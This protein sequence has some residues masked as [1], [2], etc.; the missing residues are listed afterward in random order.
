MSQK[1]G[2]LIDGIQ[3]HFTTV[4]GYQNKTNVMMQG[5]EDDIEISYRSDTSKV[6]W[7]VL[8]VA[9]AGMFDT[10]TE[11]DNARPAV[12]YSA[13]SGIDLIESSYLTW[14]TPHFIVKK[15][16]VNNVTINWPQWFGTERVSFAVLK[17]NQRKSTLSPLSYRA[18]FE[19]F[20]KD[21]EVRKSHLE[22]IGTN[23]EMNR[24]TT[25]LKSYTVTVVQPWFYTLSKSFSIKLFKLP[26]DSVTHTYAF[27]DFWEMLEVRFNGELV[28]IEHK[29]MYLED[30]TPEDAK[31][32]N[33]NPTMKFYV[34]RLHT[35]EQNQH[36]DVG[37][38]SIYEFVD[39][40]LKLV[41]SQGT[42]NIS[43]AP[44]D[45]TISVGGICRAIFWLTHECETSKENIISG[46]VGTSYPR[47]P[48]NLPNN[49]F[50][51]IEQMRFKGTSKDIKVACFANDPLSEKVVPGTDLVMTSAKMLLNVDKTG[52]ISV[53]TLLSNEIKYKHVPIVTELPDTSPKANTVKK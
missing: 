33:D 39:V 23:S 6:P 25:D 13:P 17:V 42:R 16:Y 20:I 47:Y 49:H 38:E 46:H 3:Y 18:Y 5:E 41:L 11:E 27:R 51:L 30:L 19:L 37:P 36:L 31:L 44:K 29:K 24:P 35:F 2:G 43:L 52:Y 45:K 15:E 7:S 4:S 40:Q 10:S 26:T 21:P 48:D 9:E 12:V 50:K 53:C 1:I 28:D 14:I 34:A 32:F 8:N 22:S